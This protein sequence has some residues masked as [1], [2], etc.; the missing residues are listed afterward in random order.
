MSRS[1][2]TRKT[3]NM[4]AKVRTLMDVVKRSAN[5]AQFQM[6]SAIAAFGRECAS[7]G[8]H[9][10]RMEAAGAFLTL[11][12]RVRKDEYAKTSGEG[13]YPAV[14]KALKRLDQDVRKRFPG[15]VPNG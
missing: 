3:A 5:S 6:N 11:V 14:E 8:E 2:L 9:E 12:E 15:V 1:N 4:G 10:G 7:E 13:Y